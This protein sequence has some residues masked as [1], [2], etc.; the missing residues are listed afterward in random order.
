MGIQH[1]ICLKCDKILIKT[2]ISPVLQILGYTLS[3]LIKYIY[4]A[5]LRAVMSVLNLLPNNYVSYYLQYHKL[6]YL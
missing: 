1:R 3:F 2:I 5:F 6:Y 4:I